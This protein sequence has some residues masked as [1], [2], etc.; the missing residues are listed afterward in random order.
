MLTSMYMGEAELVG[1][2]KHI[3]CED[4]IMWNQYTIGSHIMIRGKHDMKKTRSE[5][6]HFLNARM[7]EK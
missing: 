3:L 7:E 1:F 4:I 5:I 6:I 2:I